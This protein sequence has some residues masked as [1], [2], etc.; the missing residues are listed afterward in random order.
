MLQ[1]DAVK[2]PRQVGVSK[3]TFETMGSDAL[4]VPAR[5]EL[6]HLLGTK[7]KRLWYGQPTPHDVVLEFAVIALRIIQVEFP[8]PADLLAGKRRE[9]LLKLRQQSLGL[10]AELLK[11]SEGVRFGLAKVRHTLKPLGEDILE[12]A[13]I[14]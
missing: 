3:A 14:W 4:G 9:P 1:A 6:S 8:N 12:L 5:C 10:C 2:L 11:F 7:L 13:R